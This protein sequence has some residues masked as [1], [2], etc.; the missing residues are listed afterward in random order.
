MSAYAEA[1]EALRGTPGWDGLT[2]GARA[3]IPA[4]LQR[5]AEAPSQSQSVP[6]LRA[7]LD[8]CPA[9]LQAA[10]EAVHRSVAGERVV[11]IS[12]QSYFADGVETEEQLNAAL[13]GIREE[14]ERLIGSDK[15]IIV[16]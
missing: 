14:C 13:D 7:D 5:H 16:R 8:A 15:K 10:I 6:Q 4:P 12:L 11:T 3:G 2:D 1:L 9:R